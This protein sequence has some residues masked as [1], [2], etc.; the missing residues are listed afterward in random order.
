MIG[1]FKD[2]ARESRR[3]C[4]YKDTRTRRSVEH[5][6]LESKKLDGIER[7]YVKAD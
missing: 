4:P 6:V 1:N 3:T 7:D 5:G 2:N